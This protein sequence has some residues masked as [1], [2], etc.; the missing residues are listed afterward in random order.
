MFSHIPGL[1]KNNRDRV[2]V[3]ASAASEGGA[4]SI[5]NEFCASKKND[6]R[7]YILI[8]PFKP[9]V[10]PNNSKWIKL[11]T[12]GISSLFFSLIGSWF[13]AVF[14]RCDK[15]ISFSNVNTILPF[16]ERV[17]YF[18]NLLIITDR[19]LKF[20][21]LRFAIKYLNQNDVTYIFQTDYVKAVFLKNIISNIKNSVFWPGL[22]FGETLVESELKFTFDENEFYLVVPITNI[23]YVHKN[24]L[25][26]VECAKRNPSVNFL[27]TTDKL[28]KD[29]PENVIAINSLSKSDFVYAIK[30]SDG[31]LITSEYETLCL[32][33]FEALQMN[34][35]AFVLQR[36]YVDGLIS[37][38]GSIEG[39]L[40]F[41]EIDSLNKQIESSKLIDKNFAKAKYSIGQWDF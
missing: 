41:T 20:K 23:N 10:L 21:V 14:Y 36:D 32:P 16:R 31:V 38:F 13:Y 15:L 25:L 2:L 24:F 40:L 17:T 12:N 22:S 34:K 27:V 3:N 18:H 11:S 19:A 7:F 28:P 35:P 26:V 37:M 30:L 4:L 6:E 8:S 33:I 5:F 39:L 9:D 1:G 29:V